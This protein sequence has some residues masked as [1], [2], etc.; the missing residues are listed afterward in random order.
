LLAAMMGIATGTTGLPFYTFGLFIVPLGAAF[1]WSQTEIASSGLIK[2]VATMLIAGYTGRLADRLGVRRIAIIS[3]TLTALALLSFTMLTPSILSYYAVSCLLAVCGAG[4]T[5]VIWTRGVSGWFHRHRGMAIGLTLIGTGI[6]SI[7]APPIVDYAIRMGGWRMGYASLALMT[8]LVGLPLVIAL[9]REAPR[10]AVTPHAALAAEPDAS[11]S[12]AQALRT[13]QFW[14]LWFS[15]LLAGGAISIMIVYLVPMLTAAGM[16]RGH[17]VSLASTMGMAVVI[18]RLSVGWL[19]DRVSGPLLALVS[20]LLCACAI[21]GLATLPAGSPLITLCVLGVGYCAGA[22]IDLL[23]FLSS[24]YFGLRSYTEI[25]SWLFVA[26]SVGSGI[27][28]VMAAYAHDHTGG[29]SLAAHTSAGVLVLAALL[30]GTLG[31]YR[32]AR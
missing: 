1:H 12:L 10:Q 9:F 23:A 5:P 24:R 2:M 15:I 32:F 25:G 18:G 27:A 22:E 20:F 28:P 6:S 3:L 14:Q 19:L 13:R 7:V 8:G 4:T 11:L 21:F 17:A 30:F 31:K 16:T 29:Y 26:F